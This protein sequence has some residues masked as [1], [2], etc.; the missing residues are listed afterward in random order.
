MKKPSIKPLP[1]PLIPGINASSEQAGR[2]SYVLMGTGVPPVLRL[3]IQEMP[4][5]IQRTAQNG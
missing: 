2:P 3:E 4:N 5:Q 1:V